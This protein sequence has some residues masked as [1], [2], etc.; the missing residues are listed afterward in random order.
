VG[1]GDK[2]AIREVQG[3]ARSRGQKALAEERE[4]ARL[5]LRGI[6]SAYQKEPTKGGGQVTYFIKRRA[7]NGMT[8]SSAG[9][10]TS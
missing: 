2:R 7:R 8:T 3:V 10:G 9:A 4:P 6:R 1:G 5:A